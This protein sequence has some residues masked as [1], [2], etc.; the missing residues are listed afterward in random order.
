MDKRAAFIAATRKASL[1]PIDLTD[2]GIEDQ[3]Y[4]RPMTGREVSEY[5]SKWANAESAE[6]GMDALFTMVSI[7]LCYEDGNNVFPLDDPNIRD[8]PVPV[9]KHISEKA[10]EINGFD[11]DT[12]EVAENLSETPGE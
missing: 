1:S 7:S 8:I 5:A 9:A 10:K 4:L 6:D 11:Q 12:E 3:Y 2:F